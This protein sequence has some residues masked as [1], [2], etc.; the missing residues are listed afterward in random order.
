MNALKQIIA[1][2]NNNIKNM[3]KKAL[4]QSDRAYGG[5]LR[6][7]KGSLH[8][9]ITEELIKLAWSKISR[10][11][12]R[13]SINSKKI[14]I[15]INQSYIENIQNQEIKK[16]IYSNIKNYYYGLSVDKHIFIDN[17]FVIGIECKA[18]TENAMIKR[19][20]IDFHLLKTIHP[21]I[22]CYLFQLESQL[23]GDYSKL[24]QTIYG[25]YSTHS[26]MSYFRDVNLNIFTFLK[27]ERDINNPIHKTFKPLKIEIL[28]KA[29]TM[30]ENDLR[31]FS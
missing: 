1:T 15:P 29:V 2:Y 21:G 30:L 16:Y 20:L 10:D 13:L 22:S 8:E 6:Q 23:G 11:K 28:N 31:R 4:D 18:Y 12:N 14:K 5:M 26:I 3:D 25:S 17:K 24:P 7:I 19:I 27:G 9:Y